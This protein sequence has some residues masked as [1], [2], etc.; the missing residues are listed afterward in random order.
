MPAIIPERLQQQ[1]S[2]ALADID[3]P[4]ACRRKIV[5]LLEFYAERKRRPAASIGPDDVL[6]AFDTAQPVLRY[7]SRAL[8]MAL[9]E[10][11]KQAK[12]IASELWDADYRETK[13]LASAILE[14]RAEPWIPDWCAE[15]AGDCQ[16]IKALA[17]L[18]DRGLAGLRSSWPDQFLASIADWLK[19]SKPHM[20]AFALMGLEAAVC[21]PTFDALPEIYEALGLFEWEI[22]GE[23]HRV[24]LKLL[25]TLAH[26]SPQE[27]ARFLLDEIG[28]DR[29]MARSLVED[30]LSAF[31][32][33][34]RRLLRQALSD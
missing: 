2:A 26:H 24:M 34:Q 23:V 6:W 7:L 30:T 25:I 28:N 11:P 15:R 18:A 16:D 8:Q 4:S 19:M 22:R 5:D 29:L 10:H 13:M 27:T 33:R 14:R 3:D 17:D 31:P 12:K 9:E 20:K 1:I 32:P 21:D